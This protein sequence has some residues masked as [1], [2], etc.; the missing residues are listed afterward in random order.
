MAAPR[1]LADEML[2][3]LS[4]YL[5]FLGHDTQYVRGQTDREIVEQIRRDGR[6][7]LTRDRA[8]AARVPGALLL[9]SPY[10]PD[11]LRQLHA[12]APDAGYSVTFD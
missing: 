1:W 12:E 4:R 9:A 5:R 11:Q 10:L 7:L 2:G 8:L 3:R 6:R